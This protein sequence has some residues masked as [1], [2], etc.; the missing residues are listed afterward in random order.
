MYTKI[1]KKHTPIMGFAEWLDVVV[2]LDSIHKQ[3]VWHVNRNMV[4]I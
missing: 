4:V 2:I 1:N 3:Y